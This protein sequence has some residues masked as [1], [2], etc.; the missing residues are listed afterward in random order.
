METGAVQDLFMPNP[1]RGN[2]K[3]HAIIAL[4]RSSYS[5]LLLCF[6]SKYINHLQTCTCNIYTY[7]VHV[8]SITYPTPSCLD[9]AII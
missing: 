5:E 8:P 6:D 3:P 2:I 1:S 7:I 9:N 4:P